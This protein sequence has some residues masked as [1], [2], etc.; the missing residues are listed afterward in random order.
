MTDQLLKERPK[1]DKEFDIPQELIET[2]FEELPPGEVV[3]ASNPCA[4]G[5]RRIITGIALSYITLSFLALDHILPAIGAAMLFLGFRNL[6][7]ENPW[8]RLGYICSALRL[9]LMIP[10]LILNATVYG[11][12]IRDGQWKAVPIA[13]AGIQL[14]TL[15]AFWMAIDAVQKKAGIKER[16]F[17]AAALLLLYLLTLAA[18]F[19]GFAGTLSTL[20]MLLSFIMIIKSLVNLSDL[21]E[22]S[23]YS[24]KA[25]PVELSD[26]IL[27][28]IIAGV[29]AAG[30]LCGYAFFSGY[31]MDWLPVDTAE[32]ASGDIYLK[33]KDLGY[34]EAQLRDLSAQELELLKDADCVVVRVDERPLNNG[35]EKKEGNFIYTEYPVKELCFTHIAVRVAGDGKNGEA[36]RVIHHFRLRDE[37]NSGGTANI[38][39]WPAE[40]SDGWDGAEDLSGRLLCRQKDEDLAADYYYIGK[41]S[42]VSADF[43]GNSQNV[44]DISCDFSMPHKAS[45][46]RGYV[47]YTSTQTENGYL[48]S[49]WINYTHQNSFIQYPVKTAGE[50]ARE[51]MHIAD[52]PFKTVQAAIQFFITDGKPDPESLDE[53]VN[54]Y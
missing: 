40:T 35:V 13:A 45:D 23:G 24:I 10:Q 7:G 4:V 9:T 11:G 5:M 38:M 46:R 3:K 29:I 41:R 33:L 17:S 15:F 44:D 6:R 19:T 8:F 43:F 27:K 31:D 49:S 22:T 52:Y 53:F 26:G 2:S 20:V 12:L 34:P 16:S 37:I 32:H 1:E 21:M 51:G 30:I 42:Y 28:K 39:L 14:L 50:F 54:A 48:L 36:W 18:A 25:S 47:A